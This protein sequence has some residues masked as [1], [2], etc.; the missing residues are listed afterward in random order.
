MK[1]TLYITV[2]ILLTSAAARAQQGFG[3]STPAPSSVIDMT[4]ANKGVLFPRVALTSTADVTTVPSPANAL[5]VFN[6]ATTSLGTAQDVTP[7][8]Y[9]WSAATSQ[10]VRLITSV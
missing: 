6:T 3:T 8:F 10:W 7:G 9:Y 1:K 5:T 4:A 2:L